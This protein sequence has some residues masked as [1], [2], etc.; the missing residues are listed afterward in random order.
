MLIVWQA[1]IQ[2]IMY[3]HSN[4]KDLFRTKPRFLRPPPCSS[5]YPSPGHL[6]LTTST[7]DVEIQPLKKRAPDDMSSFNVCEIHTRKTL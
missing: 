4:E 7:F 1:V 6:S 5:T 3:S 2:V